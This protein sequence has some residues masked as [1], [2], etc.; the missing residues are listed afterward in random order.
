MAQLVQ[1]PTR[2]VAEQRPRLLIRQAS[3][4][5]IRTQIRKGWR[6]VGSAVGDEQG[7]TVFFGRDVVVS[8]C[9]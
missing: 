7:V 1:R 8:G 6:L 3:P 9:S 2:R 5:G 4:T